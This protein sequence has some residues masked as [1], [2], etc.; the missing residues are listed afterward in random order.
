M[1]GQM[2]SSC[3]LLLC[4]KDPR[5]ESNPS[6]EVFGKEK[7]VINHA[8]QTRLSASETSTPAFCVIVL[9]CVLWHGTLIIVLA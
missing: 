5:H 6:L 1:A 3:F 4:T 9:H 8:H 2:K 7:P